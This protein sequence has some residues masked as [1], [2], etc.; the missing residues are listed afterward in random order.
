MVNEEELNA[1]Q[2]IIEAAADVFEERGFDGAR[3]QQIADHAGINKALLHYYFRSKDLLFE[4]VFLI[5]AGKIFSKF[6]EAFNEE[7]S[8]FDK[9]EKFLQI[10]QDLLYKNRKFPIFFFNEISRNPEL[11]K[12]LVEKFDISKSFENI[13]KQFE[14]EK[15][16][17]IIRQDVEVPQLIV[18]II[19][20]SV[21]PYIGRPVIKE[22]MKEVDLSYEKFLD[23]RRSMVAQFVINSIKN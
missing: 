10:H 13:S 11:M 5:V 19:S 1:E 18:N 7:G 3:M 20:L 15:K 6:F 17:G 9:I 4:K 12:K 2:R 8:I 21:F 23:E 16:S 22:I 14:E